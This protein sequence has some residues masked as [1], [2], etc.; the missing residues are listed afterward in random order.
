MNIWGKKLFVHTIGNVVSPE[1]G[2]IT[3]C[4]LHYSTTQGEADSP[5][6]EKSRVI[7]FEQATKLIMLKRVK[8]TAR[9]RLPFYS[10]FEIDH[11]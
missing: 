7:T 2:K 8:V 3:H 1:T 11:I 6:R 5:E 10:A 9:Y 4:L